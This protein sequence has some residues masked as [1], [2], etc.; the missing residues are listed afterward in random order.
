MKRTKIVP[1]NR[2]Q[3]F[4]AVTELEEQGL[5]IT[6]FKP[7]YDKRNGEIV[8]FLMAQKEENDMKL[9]L[10]GKKL[11]LSD[12]CINKIHCDDC[13]IK[14]ICDTQRYAPQAV[15]EYENYYGVCKEWENEAVINAY[16]IIK[17][18]GDRYEGN[19]SF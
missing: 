8:I 9:L 17:E 15:D 6:D 3:L 1:V 13:E 10:D 5:E 18:M 19:S 16:E 11:S 12:F 2:V 14:K 4:P 7:I